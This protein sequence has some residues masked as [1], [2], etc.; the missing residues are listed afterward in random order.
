MFGSI[1][2]S[3]KFSVIL[4]AFAVTSACTAASDGAAA[5]TVQMALVS[6]S[7]TGTQYRLGGAVFTIDGPSPTVLASS[8]DPMETA[9]SATLA[10][11]AYTATLEPGWTL[12]RNDGGTFVPVQATLVSANPAS[13]TIYDAAATQLV[14]QFQTDGTIVT[15][16]F[17]QLD[18]TFT[19]DEV[20]TTTCTP[21]G[22]DCAA[23]TWCATS[24]LTGSGD[25]CVPD[26]NL[27]V[28][29]S[30]DGSLPCETYSA[31][32]DITGDGTNECIE[33]CDPA[34]F[35]STCLRSGLVCTDMGLLGYGVCL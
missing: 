9:L 5:G 25:M 2:I 35:G 4:L 19:V 21:F 28:G 27:P 24:E 18:I 23:G 29:A 33:F 22:T 20:G 11:G 26:G 32:G 1:R 3:L 34:T 6:N 14:Y 31:C 10:T 7:S 15:I 8:D 17:G 30:C 12:L 16:G 13:F